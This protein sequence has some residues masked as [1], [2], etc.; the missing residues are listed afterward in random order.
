MLTEF[1]EFLLDLLFFFFPAD[2]AA[3]FS[4]LDAEALLALA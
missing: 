4:A 3:A 2:L 1:I